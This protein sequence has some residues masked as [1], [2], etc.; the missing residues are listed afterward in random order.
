MAK[1]QPLP[2]PKEIR[3]EAIENLLLDNE[4]PRFA[5]ALI[6]K[7][8]NDVIKKLS[9]EKNLG[10]LIQS[11]LENGYYE[12]EPLLVV[13]DQKSKG[14]YRVIEGNRRVAAIKILL[15]E[16][17]M[18]EFGYLAVN[19]KY[20]VSEKIKKELTN[21][22]PIQV[23]ENK[24]ALWSYLGYRHIKGARPWDPYSKTLYILSI[25]EDYNESLEEIASR[26]GDTNVTVYKMYNGMKVLQQAEQQDYIH[27]KELKSFSFS[28]LYTILGY[29]ETLK[30]LGIKPSKKGLFV[31]R[32]IPTKNLDN[33]KLLI[34]FLY[35]D[36]EGK[37][38]PVIKSQ[39]PDLRRLN[40]VLADRKALLDLKEN[41][42]DIRALENAFIVTGGEDFG[43]E[44]M[45]SN[46]LNSL[47][48]ASGNVHLYKGDPDIFKDVEELYLVVK[49]LIERMK[50][51]KE[52]R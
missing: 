40:S 19:K 33:L 45:I 3:K 50:T 28:H 14:K 52:K 8:E 7:S 36:R 16:N 51:K 12:A 24:Q 23:Y 49:E 6:G 26:I 17:R 32:P 37:R 42:N 18:K 4:N 38:K 48:K 41:T 31:D 21:E 29:S 39:N 27:P 9:E 34:E 20:F 2:H 11:F 25:F 5:G 46:S 44:K 43:F 35:G 30:F 13:C 22:I 15:D 10:E 1:Y 47:K